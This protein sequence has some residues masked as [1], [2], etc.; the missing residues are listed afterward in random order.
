MFQPPKVLGCKPQMQGGFGSIRGLQMR[1]EMLQLWGGSSVL[2]SDS[3]G[4]EQ[5]NGVTCDR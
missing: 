2:S 1:K 5:E 3:H 4:D